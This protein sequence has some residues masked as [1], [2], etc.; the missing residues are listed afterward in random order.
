VAQNR[1]V[2]NENDLWPDTVVIPTEKK[3]QVRVTPAAEAQW[4]TFLNVVQASDHGLPLTNTLVSSNAG[5]AQG[6]LV[7]RPQHDDV[8][9]LFNAVPGPNLPQPILTNGFSTYNPAVPQILSQVHWLPNGYSVTWNGTPGR[10]QSV[11][12]VDLSPSATWSASVDGAAPSAIS[13]SDH[14]IGRL[15]IAGGTGKHVIKL[16]RTN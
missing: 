4:D 12:L 14:G 13:V 7:Q 10:T 15:R 8:L 11:F 9:V 3:W 1:T 16:T 2:Y 6:V 5:E